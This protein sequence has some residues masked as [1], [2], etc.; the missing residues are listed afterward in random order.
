MP[1]FDRR[2]FLEA[3]A[4][5]TA[6]TLTAATA[7]GAAQQPNERV[8]LAVMGVRG[9]GRD[10]IRGFSAFEDVNVTYVCDIDD[11]VVP[12]ALK[13]VNQRQK[14][15]PRVEK[16]IRRILQDKTVTAIA[17]AAPDHWHALAT[18]WACEAGKHVYVEK[19]VSHNLIEGR[20]M[21]EA[22][23]QHNRIVQVGTQRRSAPHLAAA[24]D[25]VR[26]GRLGKVP[27]VRTCIAGNRP[28]IG[29]VKD[30]P[31]PKGVDY[32][33]WLGPAPQRPFNENRFHYKWHWHWDYGT[34]EIGNNG[35]H[36]LDTVRML[37]NLDSPTRISSGGGKLFYD[38]DQQTPDTMAAVF[39]FP[40]TT[41]VWEHRVWSRTGFDGQSFSVVLY[42]E[43]GTM[44][45]DGR[46]WRVIDGIEGGEKAVEFERLHLRNF[47]DCVKQPRQPNADIEEGHKS[48]RLCHLGNIA[49]GTGHTLRFDAKTETCTGNNEANQLLRRT[50]RKPFTAAILEK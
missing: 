30:S 40:N 1:S 50:H 15:P 25:L 9:R 3:S 21:V 31:V 6:L 26:S 36:G 44:I 11:A 47:I 37:C 20:R 39:D 8:N 5:A 7:L 2:Q 32:D 14:N 28:N 42:G 35:I 13:A 16:D 45:V 29:H 12:A 24:A 18:I 48:T 23:R 46:G 38:D 33:L 43:R 10:L 27:F 22:A 34:G 49:L 4:S 41:V 19:P 17:I